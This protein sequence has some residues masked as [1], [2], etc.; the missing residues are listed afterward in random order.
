[1]KQNPKYEEEL[2]NLKKDVNMVKLSKEELSASLAKTQ[3]SFTSDEI[4]KYSRPDSVN[5]FS[6]QKIIL[7]R[8]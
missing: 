5:I 1:M 8:L 3:E 7:F 4:Y 2:K 6:Y